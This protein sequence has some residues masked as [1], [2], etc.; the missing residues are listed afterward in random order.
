MGAGGGRQPGRQVQG[1]VGAG[2]GGL[3][4]Q[5]QRGRDLIAGELADLRGKLARGGGR[6]P[7]GGTAAGQFG[8][9]GQQVGTAP[10]LQPLP[11]PHGPDQLIIIQFGETAITGDRVGQPGQ[12]GAGRGGV[13]DTAG[14]ET[15]AR[16]GRGGGWGP[17]TETGREDLPVVGGG[18]ILPFGVDLGEQVPYRHTGV[19]GWGG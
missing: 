4:G 11:G 14:F 9:R 3:A 15:S 16:P 5:G 12:H 18:A 7:L 13:K 8:H 10:G 2:A 17:R 19:L 1:Q 6:G